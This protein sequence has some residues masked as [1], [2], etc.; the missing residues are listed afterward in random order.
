MQRKQN[1]K[2]LPSSQCNHVW[3]SNQLALNPRLTTFL[4][5]NE[6]R[7]KWNERGWWGA[8]STHGQSS[9][10]AAEE[11]RPVED[12]G[13]DD[14]NSDD[15]DEEEDVVVEVEVDAELDLENQDNNDAILLY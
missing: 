15:D 4:L 13:T 1:A 11:S 12:D 6:R 5:P 9:C 3:L 10:N 7:G 8:S 14:V 2:S